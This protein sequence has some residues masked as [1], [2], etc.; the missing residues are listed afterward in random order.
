MTN[1]I[2]GIISG[3]LISILWK[4]IS[5]FITFILETLNVAYKYNINKKEKIRCA[6]VD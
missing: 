1:Y 3:I 6:K 4:I 5:P 2:L